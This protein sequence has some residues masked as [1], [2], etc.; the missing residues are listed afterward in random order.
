M[1]QARAP[2][3]STMSIA[4][5]EEAYRY[6]LPIVES[7]AGC[8]PLPRRDEQRVLGCLM[9]AANDIEAHG[10]L[11]L[12]REEGLEPALREFSSRRRHTQDLRRRAREWSHALGEH[13]V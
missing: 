5:L 12:Y 11:R 3:E 4:A 7:I 10:L 2:Q 13:H 9:Q 8:D 6:G 1:R